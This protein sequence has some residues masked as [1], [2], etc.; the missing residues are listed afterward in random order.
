MREMSSQSRRREIAAPIPSP[1]ARQ[2]RPGRARIFAPP[3]GRS[4]VAGN[5]SA[6]ATQSDIILI[7][8]SRR[9]IY[10]S[11]RTGAVRLPGML[12]FSIYL[13]YRTGTAIAGALPLR[14]LF[15]LGNFMGFAGWFLLPQYRRLALRNLEIAFANEKSPR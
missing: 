12:D 13:L 2:P 6:A 15:V 11:A 7:E 4:R 3:I 5:E 9:Q 14:V 1:L 10:P 8:A